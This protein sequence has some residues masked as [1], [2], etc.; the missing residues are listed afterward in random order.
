MVLPSTLVSQRNSELPPDQFRAPYCAAIV[1]LSFGLLE[2]RL[3]SQALFLRPS[4]LPGR[5]PLQFLPGGW[6][7]SRRTKPIWTSPHLYEGNAR[8][9][10]P[11]LLRPCALDS[12]LF[13][14]GGKDKKCIIVSLSPIPAS[15]SARRPAEKSRLKNR[16]QNGLLKIKTCRLRSAASL[17]GLLVDVTPSDGFLAD[18]ASSDKLFIAVDIGVYFLAS[19]ERAHK[20][21]SIASSSPKRYLAVL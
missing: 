13:G 21:C 8:I 3:S 7:L 12:F 2:I 5:I 10:L 9:L 15:A 11:L 1:F 14:K 18:T 4:S 6:L 19:S 16:G 17:N 20:C